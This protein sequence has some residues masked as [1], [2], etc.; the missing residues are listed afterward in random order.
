LA[1]NLGRAP[2][3]VGVHVVGHQLQSV[4]RRLLAPQD[5]IKGLAPAEGMSCHHYAALTMDFPAQRGDPDAMRNCA[6][7]ADPIR[8]EV[9]L[10]R[11]YLDARKDNQ[12][13]LDFPEFLQFGF[14]PEPIVLGNHH[15]IESNLTRAANQVKRVHGAV[16][17]IPG[18]VYV[19]VEMHRVVL[20]V[21]GPVELSYVNPPARLSN[22]AGRE[23]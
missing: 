12:P 11:T 3:G 4:Q 16:G 22:S 7:I 13:W 6:R 2:P 18:G 10:A 14:G 15:A 19:Q 21:S 20:C 23:C 8:Q 5:I 9:S 17:G 1:V